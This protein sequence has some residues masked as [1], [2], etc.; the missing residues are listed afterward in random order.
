VAFIVVAVVIVDC[1]RLL[2]PIS[3]SVI[4]W[5]VVVVV[6]YVV[7]APVASKMTL[8]MSHGP[9]FFCFCRPLGG[10]VRHLGG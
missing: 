9:F 7:V 3:V 6:I 4:R 8:T 10:R 5:V 1:R 2:G